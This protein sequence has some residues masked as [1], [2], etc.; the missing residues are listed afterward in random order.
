MRPGYVLNFS[1]AKFEEFFKTTA[2]VEIYDKKY[3]RDS[4]SKANRLR[5]FWEKASDESVAQVLDELLRIWRRAGSAGEAPEDEDYK[6]ATKII[7][8]LRGEEKASRLCKDICVENLPID[9]PKLAQILK[10]RL[11]QAQSCLESAPLGA[12]FLLGS[13]LEG[14]LLGIASKNS[15]KFKT[16]SKAPKGKKGERK[17]LK[18]W[19]LAQLI[20]VAHEVGFLRADVE[21]FSHGLRDFRN[22]IHPLEQLEAKFEPNYR[23]AS[24]CMRAL[25][26]AMED[27]SEKTD[28]QTERDAAREPSA[29]RDP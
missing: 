18:R 27:L 26:A 21:K 1:N 24:L 14:A 22:Y 19:S 4:G 20:D 16:A 28:K 13:V 29:T 7:A 23:S 12:I 10:S 15:E 9:D 2:G 5:A 25:C 6:E 11:E 8:R 3:L 17:P